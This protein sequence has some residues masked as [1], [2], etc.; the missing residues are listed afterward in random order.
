MCLSFLCVDEGRKEQVPLW[1]REGPLVL[2]LEPAW[3]RL[4]NEF[5]PDGAVLVQALLSVDSLFG[6]ATD[7]PR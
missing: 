3:R 2:A 7:D 1:I 5:D 6:P 4:I